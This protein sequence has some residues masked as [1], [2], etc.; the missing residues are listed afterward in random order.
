MDRVISYIDGFNLYFGL[1][2]KGW[3]RFYWLN[4][5][6]LSAALLKSSQSLEQVKYFSSRI[7]ANPLDPGRVKRQNLFLEATATLPQT[8]LFFGHFL[9]K[10]IRCRN[11]GATW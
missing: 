2:S 9:S 6:E 11:C 5:H 3:R 4:L 1:R 7:F 10:E 8:S